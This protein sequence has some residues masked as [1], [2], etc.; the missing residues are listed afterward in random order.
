M[1]TGEINRAGYPPTFLLCFEPL[2]LLSPVTAYW[3]WFDFNCVAIAAALMLLLRDEDRLDVRTASC[4]CA[5]AMPYTPIRENFRYAQTR[6]AAVSVANHLHDRRR[7]RYSP[8]LHWLVAA[9]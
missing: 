1:Q 5:L 8:S 6:F 3:V 4:L 7:V 2:T 9:A